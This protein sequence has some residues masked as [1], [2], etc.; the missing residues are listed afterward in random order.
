MSL[1]H[2]H[3]TTTE[4]IHTLLHT[5]LR[6][7]RYFEEFPVSIEVYKNRA[8]VRALSISWDSD[9]QDFLHLA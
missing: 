2:L 4:A 1:P 3:I 7:Q 6:L 9:T 5:L 8:Q